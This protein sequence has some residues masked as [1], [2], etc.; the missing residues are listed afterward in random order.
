MYFYGVFEK[1]EVQL[2]I[3]GHYVR[4]HL[5]QFLVVVA[6]IVEAVLQIHAPLHEVHEVGVLDVF[7]RLLEMYGAQFVDA[8]DEPSK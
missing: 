6:K 4:N 3:F 5:S 1:D 8:L 7:E 2:G